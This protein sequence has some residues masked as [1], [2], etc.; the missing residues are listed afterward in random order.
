HH[1][2]IG[3]SRRMRWLPLL[4]LAACRPAA[5]QAYLKGQLHVHTSNSGD[6]ET[7]PTRVAS[8]YAEHGF[9]FIV[10]TDH[11]HISTLAGGG[12]LVIP[13]VELTQTL[14]TCDPPR[15]DTCNLHVNALFVTDTTPL[16]WTPP[17]N[18]EVA[19]RLD[20]YSHALEEA[21]RRGG[22]AQLNHPNFH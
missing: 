7:S 10:L 20:L 14:A 21:R 18:V 6:S 12:L 3:H 13:G 19:T 16:Q 4:V 1:A 8:W 17:A 9:D 2:C 15:G 5:P 22:L 11:N